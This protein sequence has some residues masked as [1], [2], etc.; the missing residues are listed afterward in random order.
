MTAAAAVALTRAM[1]NAAGDEDWER[2]AALEAERRD[3]LADT[4]LAAEERAVLAE[5]EDLNAR[6]LERVAWSRD[7]RAERLRSLGQGRAAIEAYV[8]TP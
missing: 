5:L 7:Q 2:L 6:L 8:A 3:Q 1:L 4:V